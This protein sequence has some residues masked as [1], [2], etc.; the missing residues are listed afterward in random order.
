M[1]Y[2]ID[3]PNL[4]ALLSLGDDR[5]EATAAAADGVHAYLSAYLSNL[6]LDRTNPFGEAFKSNFYQ[7]AADGITME[8]G[9]DEASVVI[10]QTG[11]RQ[12][13]L[14]GEIKPVFAHYLSIPATPEAYGH[15]PTEFANLVPF[16]GRQKSGKIGVVGLKASDDDSDDVTGAHWQNHEFAETRSGSASRRRKRG[17]KFYKGEYE[18]TEPRGRKIQHSEGTVFYWLVESVTQQPDPTV[19]PSEEA[20]T[21]AAINSLKAYLHNVTLPKETGSIYQDPAFIRATDVY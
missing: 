10:N 5:S 11:M 6:N 14:G 7:K 19:L 13:L 17:G 2:T 4:G 8:Y 9:E 16:F 15:S 18:P 12:R 20:M 21:E 3:L 1:P